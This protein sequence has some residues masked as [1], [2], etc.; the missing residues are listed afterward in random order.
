[1][2]FVR[3]AA[4][5]PRRA[6]LGVVHTPPSGADA[7]LYDDYVRVTEPLSTR[8]IID[9][10]EVL[11]RRHGQP[12]RIIGILESLMVQLA[13]ARAHFKVPGTPPEVAELFRDKAKMKAALSAAG[14]PVARSRAHPGREPDARGFADQVGFPVVLKPP[15]GH[16]RQVD[17]PVGAYGRALRR[18]AGHG[19]RATPARFCSRSSCGARS[20]AS[21]PSH[22]DG[23]ARRFTRSLTTIPAASRLENPWIKWCLHARAERHLRGRVRRHP[24]GGLRERH[25]RPGPRRWHDPHGVVP[26]SPTAAWSSARSR[27]ARPAPTSA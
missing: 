16:G 14:L 5:A 12:Y 3:A 2:R 9:G 7:Q 13:Q 26:A 27:S 21:R 20:S 22:L 11:R 18:G 23:N 19:R 15:G 25:P 4:R 10:C 1:M 17:V 24:R 6:L 8:D